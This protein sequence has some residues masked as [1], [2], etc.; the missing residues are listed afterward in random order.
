MDGGEVRERAREVAALADEVRAV[1]FRARRAAAVDWE[2]VAAE[3]FRERLH[4]ET[5]RVLAAA[6]EVDEAASALLVHAAALDAASPVALVGDIL[7]RLAP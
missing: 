2:S 7:R 3:T 6:R 1:V 4:V 5:E